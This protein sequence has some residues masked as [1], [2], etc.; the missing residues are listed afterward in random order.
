[1]RLSRLAFLV[2]I[3]LVLP[4]LAL[5][6]IN[7]NLI[8]DRMDKTRNAGF[9]VAKYQRVLESKPAAQW[10]DTEIEHYLWSALWYVL[11]ANHVYD[12]EIGETA[13]DLHSLVDLGYMRFWP[14]NPLNDWEPIE[15]L[16]VHDEFSPGALVY[17]ICPVDFYSGLEDPRPQSYELGIYGPTPEF[18]SR[19]D[20]ETLE[21]N[22]WAVLPSGI[23][24]N[25]GAH[26]ES[27]RTT[28]AK[29]EKRLEMLKELEG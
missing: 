16:A 5:A 23:L 27:T 9:K 28:I 2:S 20:A 13:P 14:G 8:Q 1:M 24:Y 6:D 22:T 12:L 3:L 17:Q 21:L 29:I 11:Y 26:T 25:A 15:V 7:E 4:Y 10:E 19:F 18:G